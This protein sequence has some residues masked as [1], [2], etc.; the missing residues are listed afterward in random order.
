MQRTMFSA[1][2]R[3]DAGDRGTDR[4][5]E[6]GV[7]E[8]DD[9]RLA[10]QFQRDRDESPSGL[11]GEN[12]A[13]LDRAGERDPPHVRMLGQRRT[14]VRTVARDDVEDAVRKADVRREPAQQHSGL[15]RGTYREGRQDA[16]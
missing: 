5:L 10:A 4:A 1:K 15:R 16:R 6:I 9:R 14:H 2:I 8:D 11:P 3:S 12:A 7:G 13:G